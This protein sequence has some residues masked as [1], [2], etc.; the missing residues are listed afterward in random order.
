MDEV[1]V[2]FDNNGRLVVKNRAYRRA[3]KNRATLEGKPKNYYTKKKIHKRNRNG[4]ITIISKNTY[5]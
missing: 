2:G 3:F 4:K 1:K 5:K